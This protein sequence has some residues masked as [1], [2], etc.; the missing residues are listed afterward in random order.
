MTY[1]S[2]PVKKPGFQDDNANCGENQPRECYCGGQKQN[3]FQYLMD[4]MGPAHLDPATLAISTPADGAWVKPGFLVKADVMS[5]LSVKA[6]DL[7]IDGAN[8][9]SIDASPLVFHALMTLAGGDHVVA[10]NATDAAQRMFGA[11]V[12]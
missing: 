8:S 11:Q 12:T 4:T 5:Q 1:L 6:A 2:P 7:S 10:V 3:S 9:S